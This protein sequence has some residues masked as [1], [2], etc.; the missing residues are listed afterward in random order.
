[1]GYEAPVY[2]AWGQKNR[3]AY[4]RVPEYQPGKKEATRIE[5]RSPDPACN[6]YLCFATTIT[7]GLDG[8][9]KKSLLPKPVEDNIFNM[10][11]SS[12]KKLHINT[13]PSN[14]HNALRKMK[15]SKLV[16]EAL[17]EH[18]FQKF[19][20]NKKYEIEQYNKSV[21]KEFDKQVSEY[22]IEKYLPVL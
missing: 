3:S 8:I 1:V 11:R 10:S 21:S 13:L 17:G 20:L 16:R 14:L 15:K 5:L 7:A 18:L 6:L 2:I 22:E 4:I 12:Q 19:L 9:R